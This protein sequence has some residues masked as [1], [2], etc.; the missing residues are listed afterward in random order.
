[1]NAYLEEAPNS[2]VSITNVLGQTNQ[3]NTPGKLVFMINNQPYRLDALE[4]SPGELFIIFGDATC[5][6]ET[7]P[8]GRFMYVKKP[9]R[10]ATIIV[11]F[12]KAFNPPCAF[13]EFATCPLPPKQNILP[14]A[15]KAGE[16]WETINN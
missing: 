12:N 16:R 5:G 10:G 13:S 7:Y 9:A 6:K 15:I 4:E 3:Q 14:I 2:F 8:A 11:D 1:M